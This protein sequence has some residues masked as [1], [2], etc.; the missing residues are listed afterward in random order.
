MMKALITL[1]ALMAWCPQSGAAVLFD[2]NEVIEIQL[3]GPLKSTFKDSADRNERQFLLEVDGIDIPVAVRMRGKSRARICKFPPL[4]LN[5]AGSD[6]RNTV[7]EGQQSLKLVTHCRSGDR[8][9]LNVLEEFAAYRIFNLISDYSYRVRLLRINYLDTDEKPGKGEMLQYGFVIEPGAQLQSREG[10]EWVKRSGVKMSQVA[11]Y[12]AA[13]V[14]VFQYLIGNTDWSFAMADGD[15]SCCH[16][17]NLLEIDSELYDV[18]YDFDL[19]GLVNASYAKPDP[20]VRISNVRQRRYRGYCIDPEAVRAAI[21]HIKSKQADIIA[22]LGSLPDYPKKAEAKNTE[23]LN[24]FFE[25]T[26]N[27]DK[28]L[29]RF[30][31]RCL[32]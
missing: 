15:D 16:N 3:S 31:K 18:P 24:G 25:L 13:L 23:Y 26:E 21:R 1:I 20:S 32:D 8:G 2:D 10:G 14:F 7:F 28:L 12:Q 4:K 22:V 29:A 9:K 30:D 27:E 19:S 6:T 11:E 17:G 5:F